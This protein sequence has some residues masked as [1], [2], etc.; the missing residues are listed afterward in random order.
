MGMGM[1]IGMRMGMEI[2]EGNGVMVM[3]YCIMLC[4]VMLCYENGDGDGVRYNLLFFLVGG[5]SWL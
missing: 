4:Y 2:R 3:G 5:K 1:G